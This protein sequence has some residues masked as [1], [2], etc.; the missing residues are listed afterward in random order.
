MSTVTS[1]FVFTNEQIIELRNL[2]AQ[3]PKP[4]QPPK[5]SYT[6]PVIASAK[7]AGSR[8]EVY[9]PFWD[10]IHVKGDYKSREFHWHGIIMERALIYLR[11]KSID[12]TKTQFIEDDEQLAYLYFDKSVKEKYFEN[13]YPKSIDTD[14]LSKWLDEYHWG[15]ETQGILDS[16]KHLHDCFHFIDDNHVV[17][18]HTDYIA[19]VIK[20]VPLKEMTDGTVKQKS[21]QYL[22][23]NC[24]KRITKV[25]HGVKRISEIPDGQKQICG[26][27]FNITTELKNGKEVEHT[28]ETTHRFKGSC[29]APATGCYRRPM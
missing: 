21:I 26:D 16:I 18:L 23:D 5:N 7:D 11:E 8:Y 13:I 1:V 20:S 27:Q 12:L 25:W 6:V 9:Q 24:G 4:G 19:E 17:L 14:D 22:C 10:Y 2:A 15:T 29:E 28:F 3:I